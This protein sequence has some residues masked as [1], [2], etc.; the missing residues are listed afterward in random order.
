MIAGFPENGLERIEPDQG[1]DGLVRR[2][3][4][5]TLCARHLPQPP[6]PI[7]QVHEEARVLI[8]SQAPG[9]HAHRAGI[10]FADASGERLR[11][12]LGVDERT[13][14]D[15][16][17]FAILPMGFC[18][19]GRGASGDAPP[20]RECAPAWRRAFLDRLPSI[21]LTLVVGAH[22]LHWHLE[23][24]SL[25]DAVRNWRAYWPRVLP[26]PHPSPRNR[27]WL[28]RNPWFE[29]EVVPELR[30]RIRQLS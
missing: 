10:P 22:A 30:S 4:A 25:T 14:R 23:S 15:P 3:R 28:A 2:A 9:R 29:A 20:R 26:M 21:E 19:P 6:K 1:L 16:R 17:V 24:K 12:W 5:C 8:A 13:F 7:F 27:A 11:A 18:D